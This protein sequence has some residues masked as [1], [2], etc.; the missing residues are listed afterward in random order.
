L[1]NPLSRPL[2]HYK[3]EFQIND[4]DDFCVEHQPSICDIAALKQG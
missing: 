1:L 4:D 2:M 3:L